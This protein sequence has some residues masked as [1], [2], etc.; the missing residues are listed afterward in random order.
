MHW[1]NP[2]LQILLGGICEAVHVNWGRSSRRLGDRLAQLFL[3]S[4]S[5]PSVGFPTAAFHHGFMVITFHRL[6]RVPI[7]MRQLAPNRSRSSARANKDR[8]EGRLEQQSPFTR[9]VATTATSTSTHCKFMPGPSR[10]PKKQVR[11]IYAHTHTQAPNGYEL[12]G[13]PTI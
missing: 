1:E 9:F 7:P 4:C 6:E 13:Q 8:R 12:A 5:S 11:D 3:F 2:L 10:A